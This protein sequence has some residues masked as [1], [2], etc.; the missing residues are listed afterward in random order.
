MAD[1]HQIIVVSADPSSTDTQW[2]VSKVPTT[3]PDHATPCSSRGISFA[4]IASQYRDSRGNPLHRAY[5]ELASRV[6]LMLAGDQPRS[7]IM[8]VLDGLLLGRTP[9]LVL[10]KDPDALRPEFEAQGVIVASANAPAERVVQMLHTLA[11]RQ[12]AVAMLAT[13][14][15]IAR[16]SQGGISG[17]MS[18]LH[19]ELQLAGTL[20]RR[21]LPKTLPEPDG[22]RFGVLF[23]PCGYVSG[24]IYDIVQIDDHRVA[25]LLA[26]AVGHGVPAALL[27]L[28][29]V[30][31]LRQPD[32]GLT[33]AFA[34]PAEILSRLNKELALENDSGDRFA[35]AVCGVIDTQT[36]ELT[37]ASAGHPPPL[38]ID[39]KGKTTCFRGGEGPLLGVFE[40][41]EFSQ[42]TCP[43]APT[44][45]LLLY[46]DGFETA[47]PEPSNDPTRAGANEQYINHFS[48]A[49]SHASEH[50]QGLQLAL[51]RLAQKIDTCVGS[52]RQR[53]DLTIVAIG[54][55]PAPDF[56]CNTASRPADTQSL[57]SSHPAA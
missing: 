53:D 48:D 40:E 45:T 20:Q 38:M 33:H 14:L 10:S 30:R 39:T 54:R 17:E 25:F 34:T 37:I 12:A 24:D 21:F 35:T 2:W 56:L 19:D 47:F 3:W 32:A 1:Q 9:V 41:A 23:R 57:P 18:K 42:A 36:H 11:T 7:V 26:D 49:I 52:L 43:L 15:R 31:A 50:T 13:E 27:T 8:P 51:E 44:H 28:V 55:L 46:S 16:A 5:P 6:V 22:Y 4:D 29:L